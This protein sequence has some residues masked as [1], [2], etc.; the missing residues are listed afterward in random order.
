[1]EVGKAVFSI[2]STDTD[3]LAIVGASIFPE[4]AGVE[5]EGPF[6]AYTVSAVQPSAI[7]AS[8]STLD[9]SDIDVY[10][11]AKD[12]AVAMDLAIAMR[13]ALDRNGGNIAG[14]QVQSIIFR[15]SSV[16]WID[17]R[18]L[19]VVSQGYTVRIQRTGQ[20]PDFTLIGT[21]NAL[22]V[23]EVDG[24]PIGAVDTIKFPNGSLTLAGGAATVSL[25]TSTDLE[26]TATN[27]VYSRAAMSA[28]VLYGGASAEDYGSA[29]PREAK[30][31]TAEVTAQGLTFSPSG[32]TVTIGATG[33]YRL[34]ATV[35]FI[36]ASKSAAKMYFK[37]GS[38]A[39]SGADHAFILTGSGIDHATAHISRV[40]QFSEGHVASVHI[41]DSSTETGNIF[42]TEGIWE[43]ERIA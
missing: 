10:G 9:T 41:E 24:S 23:T 26:F 15:S 38:T 34:T 25:I 20:A 28:A 43:V 27:F 37:R 21:D 14:V 35:T 2:L 13:A 16:D 22:T 39:L 42:A 1:M 11:V 12:Y 8:T 40:Y 32:N 33:Y 19:Y 36:S 30:F 31:D 4:R 7:E 29:T 3:V 17:E 6:V 18:E 5:V